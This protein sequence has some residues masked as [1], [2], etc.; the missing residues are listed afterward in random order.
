MAEAAPAE[1][2]E[3]DGLPPIE[4]PMEIAAAAPLVE[5]AVEEVVPEAMVIEED[6][7][8]PPVSPFSIFLRLFIFLIAILF[9][10]SETPQVPQ[11][12][13]YPGIPCQLD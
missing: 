4:D 6:H 1:V 9:S 5:A 12:G 2:T 7:L 13:L 11:S 8:P 10:F 3:E